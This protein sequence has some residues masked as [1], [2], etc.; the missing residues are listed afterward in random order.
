[1]PTEPGLASV[2]VSASHSSHPE[3]SASLPPDHFVCGHQYE[4]DRHQKDAGLQE[5]VVSESLEKQGHRE[6]DQGHKNGDQE[7]LFDR[8]RMFLFIM[9]FE[10]LPASQA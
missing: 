6:K 4:F 5:Q 7:A 10:R 8:R 1:M 2:S 3:F 9:G